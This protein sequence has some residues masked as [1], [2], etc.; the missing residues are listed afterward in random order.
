M[1]ESRRDRIAKWQSQFTE[2][3][4]AGDNQAAFGVIDEALKL[5]SHPSEI[6]VEMIAPSQIQIGN[7]W[8]E[9]AINIAQ[10]HVA[11]ELTI[12]CMSYLRSSIEPAPFNGYHAVISSLEGDHHS[13]PPRFIADLLYFA[14]WNVDFLGSNI[15]VRDLVNH[16]EQIQTDLVAISLTILKSIES[17]EECIA[18][19]RDLPK[20]PRILVGGY[21]TLDPAFDDFRTHWDLAIVPQDAIEAIHLASKLVEPNDLEIRIDQLLLQTGARIRQLRSAR[22]WSQEA[23]AN[24]SA[25]DRSYIC[26][27]ENG[28]QNP[29]MGVLKKLSDALDIPVEEIIAEKPF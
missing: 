1:L 13:L 5:A 21:A 25:L 18:S 22:N 26:S 8:L 11:T 4:I 23:L 6:Y 27:L 16:A 9:G 3:A 29:M 19:L 2:S 17:F 28:R 15:P 10:E 20:K 14:G 7:H 12:E 24:A